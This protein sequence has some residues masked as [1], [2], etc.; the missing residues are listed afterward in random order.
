MSSILHSGLW[1]PDILKS[2]PWTPAVQKKKI[3]FDPDEVSPFWSTP[4]GIQIL[5]SLL[6]KYSEDQPRDSHGRF[7]SGESGDTKDKELAPHLSYISNAVESFRAAGGE[8]KLL[9]PGFDTDE[10]EKMAS[11][12]TSTMDKI[13]D[14]YTSKLMTSSEVTQVDKL[15]TALNAMRAAV[16]DT[17][18]G[19]TE[20]VFVAYDKN[21]SPVAALSFNEPMGESLSIGYLGST[22]TVAGAG[23]ALQYELAQ[24]AANEHV[25][26]DSVSGMGSQNYHEL[27]G[28]TVDNAGS[29]TWTDEQVQQIAD[30]NLPS[31]QKLFKYDEDQERDYHGRFAEDTAFPVAGMKLGGEFQSGDVIT[32]GR[33]GD[34]TIVSIKPEDKPGSSY[35]TILGIKEDGSKVKFNVSG[36]KHYP[37]KDLTTNSK[38]QTAVSPPE[39]NKPETGERLNYGDISP[40]LGKIIA[41]AGIQTATDKQWND[42]QTAVRNGTPVDPAT[43]DAVGREIS[44]INKIGTTFKVEHDYE[45]EEVPSHYDE[46]KRYVSSYSILTGETLTVTQTPKEEQEQAQRSGWRQDNGFTSLLSIGRSTIERNTDVD[47]KDKGYFYARGESK[48]NP[49]QISALTK[50]VGRVDA[51]S[52]YVNFGTMKASDFPSGQMP[53][54]SLFVSSA[55]PQSEAA[56]EYIKYGEDL[57]NDRLGETRNQIAEVGYNRLIAEL[58]FE[59]MQEIR[60]S[61][62]KELQGRVP[63]V[64]VDSSVVEKILKGASLGNLFT[65]NKTGAGAGAGE[66]YRTIRRLE[67]ADSMGYK[68]DTS[69]EN[70]PVYGLMETKDSVSSHV[71]TSDAEIDLA[72][73]RA[74]GLNAYIRE[75]DENGKF[76]EYRTATSL[77]D[78]IDANIRSDNEQAQKILDDRASGGDKLAAYPEMYSDERLKSFQEHTVL[79]ERLAQIQDIKNNPQNYVAVAGK[80][81]NWDYNRWFDT[82]EIRSKQAIQDEIQSTRQKVEDKQYS[83]SAHDKKDISSSIGALK[84]YKMYELALPDGS[85]NKDTIAWQNTQAN[86]DLSH[87]GDSTIVLKDSVLANSTVTPGDSLDYAQVTAIPYELA[88]S[89]DPSAPVPMHERMDVGATGPEDKIPGL[90]GEQPHIGEY[91]EVQ[92]GGTHPTASDIEKIIFTNGRPSDSAVKK[93][94]SLGIYYEIAYPNFDSKNFT[95]IDSSLIPEK[96]KR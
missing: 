28:R 50:L 86:D 24:Y 62:A 15:T 55:N 34:V 66:R 52:T 36:N 85:L 12:L 10:L 43:W 9:D 63:V 59:Q 75:V 38:P 1:R 73:G 14:S 22:L 21:G 33:H 80:D 65:E 4:E 95:K 40:E 27:I 41:D 78:A 51:V 58:T 76:S 26:V 30:L 23:T 8:V 47:G 31:L 25:G 37:V 46:N 48:L 54:T 2:Q 93:L 35:H 17:L 88:V 87:F 74:V 70:R 56:Q 90:N 3:D 49:E 45:K 84:S 11:N 13:Y 42:F 82:Y 72:L 64:K 69:G 44:G 19:I 60:E 29:S 61:Y 81:L 5:T 83:R 68:L 20:N 6:K 16:T 57:S 71:G 79:N 67:E 39:I 7:A 89:A 94:E 91:Y 77:Q 92:I 32:W 96:P 18:S 53:Y